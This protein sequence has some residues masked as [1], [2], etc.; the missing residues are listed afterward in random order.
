V[1][2]VEPAPCHRE[3]VAAVAEMALPEPGERGGRS[4]GDG[5]GI[6]ACKFCRKVQG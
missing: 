2:V 4:S 5:S 1:A 6:C 3:M